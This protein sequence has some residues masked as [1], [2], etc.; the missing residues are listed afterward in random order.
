MPRFSRKTLVLFPVFATALLI[1]RLTKQWIIDRFSY[2]EQQVVIPH[3]FNL[4][5]VRNPGGAFSFLAT[6]S[7][8]VRQLFFLG[9]GVFAILLLLV[10]FR[11]LESSAWLSALAIGAILGGAIGNLTDRIV[12]GEVIDFLDFRLVGGYVW[13]TFNI[14]DCCI[15]VGVGILMLEMLFEHEPGPR[16][17]DPEYDS[18]LTAR[19]PGSSS[20]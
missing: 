13:P 16:H 17:E 10:F 14:A 9:A 11:R 3:F 8:D 12:Y 7:G 20:S 19:S 18:E 4:T 5:H 2:G 1:D 6:M 15:V